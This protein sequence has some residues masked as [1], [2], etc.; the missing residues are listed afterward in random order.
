MPQRL[1]RV[2]S[3]VNAKGDAVVWKIFV[4]SF[5]LMICPQT[6]KSMLPLASLLVSNK[7]QASPV[8][9]PVH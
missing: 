5:E 4:P 6:A 1:P 7:A 8:F 9:L 3:H 2:L